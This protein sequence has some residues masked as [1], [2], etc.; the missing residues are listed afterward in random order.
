MTD[1]TIERLKTL[2]RIAE[3]YSSEA[4]KLPL[5]RR[6]EFDVVQE[7]YTLFLGSILTV[8]DVLLEED[9]P[10]ADIA[11]VL[12]NETE[13]GQLFRDRGINREALEQMLLMRRFQ[14]QKAPIFTYRSSLCLR[15]H[16]MD[17]GKSVPM[18][19][20]RPPYDT[21]FIEMGPAESRGELAFEVAAN[22][23][24]LPLEGAYVSYHADA[25]GEILSDRGRE[26]LAI[27]R[28]KP[29]RCM[30]IAFSGSPTKMTDHR[31]SILS[32]PAMYL[33]IYWTDDDQAIEATLNKNLALITER[34]E[35]PEAEYST[36]RINMQL[37]TK[38]MLYL[39]TGNRE[40][41][42]DK[43][44][45]SSLDRMINLKSPAKLRKVARQTERQYDRILVGPNKPYLPISEAVDNVEQRTGV[46]PHFRRAHW[47]T[48]RVGVGR[49]EVRAVQIGVTLV[50]KEG[51]SDDEAS[52]LVRDYDVY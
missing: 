31:Q 1:R 39:A 35:L 15:L 46:K 40:Q 44:L 8:I 27:E 49:T 52:A 41:I 32:D 51:L 11:R 22:N 24:V 20:L 23:H 28:N 48:R 45:S 37:L 6:F 9:K 2:S 36:I 43:A 50:N 18:S 47:S 10:A 38:A 25:S 34:K 5:P 21:C 12:L 26:I 17:I 16:D 14:L 30:E 33:S 13:H 4:L 29:L 7:Y 42:E 19:F 3:S